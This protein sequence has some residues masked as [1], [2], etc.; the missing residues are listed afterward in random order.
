MHL[1]R[2][3]IERCGLQL[4]GPYHSTPPPSPPNGSN[5]KGPPAN[6]INLFSDAAAD[7]YR[8]RCWSDRSN[9]YH[10]LVPITHAAYVRRPGRTL[11]PHNSSANA[12]PET[13]QGVEGGGLD[14]ERQSLR[15]ITQIIILNPVRSH[16]PDRHR[17]GA[18]GASA[19]AR[20]SAIVSISIGIIQ[21][22][23]EVLCDAL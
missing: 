11:G 4:N 3:P 22:T 20:A 1:H 12:D 23:H 9:C 16:A 7:M 10:S 2:S 17:T 18:N 8:R 19:P 6:I 14:P 5:K 13:Q 15:A 21:M